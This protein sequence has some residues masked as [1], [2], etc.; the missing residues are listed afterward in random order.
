MNTSPT[1]LSVPRIHWVLI[2][3]RNNLHLTRACIR[4]LRAQDIGEV[5]ILLIDNQSTDGTSSWC[6]SQRDLFR[7]HFDPP[8]SVAA[9]WNRGLDF[10][11]KMGAEYCWVVNNDT[12]F[13]PESYRHLVEDGGD[14]VT[15]VGVRK[16]PSEIN[17]PP[18]PEN[19]RPHPD[20][21]SFLIRRKVFEQVGPFDERFLIAFGEDWDLHVRLH[22]AGIWAH[23][24]DMPFL[25]HGS[26]TIK[27]ADPTEVRRIQK[28]AERN[29]AYFKQKWGMSGASQEYYDFF[30]SA[31][32]PSPPSE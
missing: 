3:V 14:F 1:S 11:F 16:W 26:Q 29:R 23:C 10:V 24:I 2:P 25:H 22:K 21:S 15:L 6:N 9:S 27:N 31:P 5:G 13:R 8:L 30:G 4:S 18:K 17:L 32:P 7:M 28:Q 20:F 12:E 19:N